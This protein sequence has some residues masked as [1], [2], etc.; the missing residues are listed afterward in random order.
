LDTI[1]ERC[2]EHDLFIAVPVLQ[3]IF[4]ETIW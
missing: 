3:T 2:R 1:Y 4:E